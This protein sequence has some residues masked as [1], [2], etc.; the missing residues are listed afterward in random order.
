[1]LCHITP[2]SYAVAKEQEEEVVVVV[3]EEESMVGEGALKDSNA[4]FLEPWCRY[5]RVLIGCK[6]LIGCNNIIIREIA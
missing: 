6:R 4:V 2:L 3:E 1:M 5:V